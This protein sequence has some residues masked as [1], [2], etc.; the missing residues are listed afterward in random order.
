MKRILLVVAEASLLLCACGSLADIR[1]VTPAPWNGDSQ[2]WQ[3]QR[4]AEKMNTVTNGGAKVVFIGDSITHFWETTGKA[5]WK[6]YFSSGRRAALNLGTSGDRTEHVLWRLAEG[7]ELDGYEAKCILLMIGTNNTGHYSFAEEPPVDTILGIKRI[8]EVI[9][10]KQPAARTILTAIFPRGADAND[11]LR[12]R[13]D[14]VNK[15]IA[16]FADGRKVIWCDFSDKFLDGEGRLSRELFPDLLHPGS[17]GYEIWASAVLPLIDK[18]L[19]A[20]DDEVVPS[21]WPSVPRTYSASANLSAEPV[22]GF[23]DFMWWGKGRPL[24]KRNEIADNMSVGYDLVMVGDSITH[25]WER[26]GGEGR[27][28]F[29]ELKKRY[30][31]LNL[32]YGGDQTRHLIWRLANGELEGYKAKVFQVMIGTN[33]RDGAPEQTA[34]GVKRVIDV[35]REK[36]PESKV[37]LL[38][39]FPRGATADDKRRVQNEKVNAIIKDFADGGKVIWFDFNYRYFNA[40]GALTKEVMND[41]L[42]PNEKGYKIWL[43]ALEPKLE[44]LCGRVAASNEN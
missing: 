5:Q 20:Q 1:S 10:E 17:L 6:K 19:D 36:H 12:L 34:A 8:L 7:G 25:R 43:D 2:C 31:V 14:V 35:I 44:A 32:G 24:E 27:E 22:S 11:P 3:M 33:N 41:L 42:H 37:L 21:V 38:P 29:A 30:S 9:A 28:L 18:V 13:N 39:I 23:P 26:E 16:K 40:D 15:E 4:H